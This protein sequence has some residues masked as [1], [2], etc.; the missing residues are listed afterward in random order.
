[1][2]VGSI[3]RKLGPRWEE[4]GEKWQF[5]V[6]DWLSQFLGRLRKNAA[7]VCTMEPQWPMSPGGP[8]GQGKRGA[9]WVRLRLGWRV[10]RF[11]DE[12]QRRPPTLVLVLGI[13]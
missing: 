6:R 4:K 12:G 2:F 3:L 10:D 7:E 13:S 1:M 11:G 8:H 5:E 9:V